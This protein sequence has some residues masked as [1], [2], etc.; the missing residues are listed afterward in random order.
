MISKHAAYTRYSFTHQNKQFF[1][2][3]FLFL[4]YLPSD[5]VVRKN[6]DDDARNAS[7][8]ITNN[9]LIKWNTVF[10]A[11]KKHDKNCT[12]T[13]NAIDNRGK[14]CR[15]C[16]LRQTWADRENATDFFFQLLDHDYELCCVSAT[17]FLM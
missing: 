1:F 6:D 17:V 12:F 15:S 7:A 3:L 8:L 5:K 10:F 16:K 14:L 4:C 13:F 2:L 11:K 9:F